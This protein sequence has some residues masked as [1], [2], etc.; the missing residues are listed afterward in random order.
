MPLINSCFHSRKIPFQIIATLN[1]LFTIGDNYGFRLH[2][3]DSLEFKIVWK[4]YHSNVTL[5]LIEPLD[6]W[7]EQ[8]YFRKLD[9]LFDI[10][11]FM[12]G[13]EDLL[14]ISNVEKF[15]K[16]IKIAYPLIDSILKGEHFD[17]FGGY[18]TSCFD[19]V[20]VND[21]ATYQVAIAREI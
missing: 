20:I 4:I 15:K 21:V 5:I 2:S 8:V 14:N 19:L 18:L 13:I 7:D 16:E 12:Y 17:L 10:L 6:A 3:I 1:S 11:V 9:L